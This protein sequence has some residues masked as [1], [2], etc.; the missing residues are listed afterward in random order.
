MQVTMLQ[1]KIHRVT[2]K[3]AR[4]DYVGSITVDPVLLNA[5][6]IAEYQLVQ[7]VN[8]TNGQRLETYAIASPTPGD[9]MVCLNGAAA[10]FFNP[11]DTA[12]IMAYAQMATEEAKTH[13]PKVVFVDEENRPVRVTHYEKAGALYQNERHA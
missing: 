5:A 2:V 7:V 8:V 4:I 6:G 9:G 1:G 3:E 13:Q 11:G 12:I 10:H